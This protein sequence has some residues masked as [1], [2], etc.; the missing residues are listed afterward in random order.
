M[1]DIKSICQIAGNVEMRD[2]LFAWWLE[3]SEKGIGSMKE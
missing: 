2:S 3:G 1:R